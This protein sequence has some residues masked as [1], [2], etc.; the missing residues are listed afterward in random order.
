MR[1]Y[2]NASNT[3]AREILGIISMAKALTLR[4]AKVFTIASFCF[5]YRKEMIV[6]PSAMPSASFPSNGGRTLSKMSA[7]LYKSSLVTNVAPAAAYW[8]SRNWAC[9]PAPYSTR[10]VLKPFLR[11]TVA[12]WGV[13]ATRRSFWNVSLGTPTVSDEY[14]IP[15]EPYQ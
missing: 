13:N 7:D 8:S 1:K 14:G 5:G 9:A 10:T 12:F 4:E 11:R 6:L 2:L 15:S 3:W